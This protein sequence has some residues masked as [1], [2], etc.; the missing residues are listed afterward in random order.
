MSTNTTTLEQF[1]YDN[2]I[3]RNFA[4]AT[5]IWGI[6]GMLVGVI[7]ATQLFE[8]AANITQYGSFG[9]IRPLHTN[10]VIFAFVGNAIFAGVYYSLQRLL[11]ARMFS[12][13]LS[14]L[15]FWGWQSLYLQP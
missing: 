5:I 7:I 9:R 3:V 10:A 2:K 1:S 4:I 11:K 13:F 15:H 12:D 6:V 14:N 8:P